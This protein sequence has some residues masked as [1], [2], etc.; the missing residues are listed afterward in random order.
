MLTEPLE[1]PDGYPTGRDR[2]ITVGP[3]RFNYQTVGTP[4]HPPIL[5]LHG[6][7]GNCH[8][9]DGAIAPLANQFYCI[10]LDLPG[11]GKTGVDHDWNYTLEN[12]ARGIGEF[13]EAIAIRRCYLV[14]YSLGG[15]VALY[16]TL[17]F[18]NYFRRT[19]LESASPGLETQTERDLRRDR[20]RK[21]AQELEEDFPLFLTKWYNQPLFASLQ[22]YPGF[23][24][25]IQQRL[26]NT[27]SRLVKSLA[28]LGTGNQP[29][30]WEKLAQNSVPTRLLVGEL[31]QKFIAINTAM[32][33][34]GKTMELAVVNRSGHNIHLENRDAFVAHLQQFFANPEETAH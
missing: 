14:G 11:H 1:S 32:V 6:F 2:S 4:D 31:D 7:M 22:N 20:D 8:E 26:N 21:L 19:V 23:E 33:H 15:R 24:Q 3:Y 29:S 17:N 13:L 5:F 10:A 25:L 16:L 30:L 9:F 34:R 28:Y 18:S 12:T 27:P